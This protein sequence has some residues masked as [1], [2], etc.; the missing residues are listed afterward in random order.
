MPKT[1]VQTLIEDADALVKAGKFQA[2]TELYRQ[3]LADHGARE[4][5]IRVRRGLMAAPY[6]GTPALVELLQQVEAISPNAFV[7]DGLATWR[8]TLPFMHDPRFLA[9]ADKHGHLLPLP[10]W[11]WNLQV[12]LWAVRQARDVPGDYVELGVFK[13]HTTLFCAEYLDFQTWPRRW[14]LYDTFEGIPDDQVDPGWAEINRKTYAGTFSYDEV[15]ASFAHIGNVDVIKGRVPEILQER[16]P[17]RIAFIHL[18]LNNATAEIAAL[19]ALYDRL[20]PGGVIVLDDYGWS[21]AHAQFIAETRWFAAR[22]LPLLSLP[23]GQGVFVKP[24]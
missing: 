14:W 4:Q 21:S 2:A 11:H 5:P 24:G 16:C 3:A 19:D 7:T 13:G 17:D 8:K 15:K 1:P 12:V 22:D 10:N 23:T 6:P 9:L 20:S 18:D